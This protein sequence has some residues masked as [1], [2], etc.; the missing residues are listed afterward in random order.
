M[1][2]LLLVFQFRESHHADQG[3]VRGETA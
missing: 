1:K 2:F 3:A